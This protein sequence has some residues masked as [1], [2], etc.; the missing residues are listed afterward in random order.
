MKLTPQFFIIADTHFL[1]SAMTKLG[2][3]PD[4]FDEIIIKNWNKIVKPKDKVL[5]LGD[6]VFSNKERAIAL[7]R[8]LNGKI[9]LVRGNHDGQSETWITDCGIKAVEPIYKVFKDKYENIIDVLFT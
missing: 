7:V 1:H 6:L 9:Y 5:H 3:R 8:K 2:G 4:D